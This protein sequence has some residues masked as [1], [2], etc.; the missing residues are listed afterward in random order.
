MINAHAPQKKRRIHQE[1]CLEN[2]V[3][4]QFAAPQMCSI[5]STRIELSNLLKVRQGQVN[6][7]AKFVFGFILRFISRIKLTL[8]LFPCDY[9]NSLQ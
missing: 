1:I 2:S 4:T 5:K 8:K 7:I 6:L 9:F 3:A